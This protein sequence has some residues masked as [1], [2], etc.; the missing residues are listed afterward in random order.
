MYIHF[1]EKKVYILTHYISVYF[2][3]ALD[4]FKNMQH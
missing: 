3:Q 1:K 2:G 4:S